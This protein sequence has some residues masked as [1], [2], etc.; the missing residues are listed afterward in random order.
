MHRIAPHAVGVVHEPIEDAVGWLARIDVL[1][2]DDWAMAPLSEP[3][4]LKLASRVLVKHRRVTG[5][6]SRVQS[7][8]Q[9]NFDLPK[10][11][12]QTA[13][14]GQVFSL[15]LDKAMLQTLVGE[16]NKLGM[17]TSKLQIEDSQGRQVSVSSQGGR[18]ILDTS[19]ATASPVPTT[20]FNSPPATSAPST[21]T[22]GSASDA[23]FV[24]QLQK[25]VQVMS[26]FGGAWNLNPAYFATRDTAQWLANKFGTGEVVEVPYGGQGGPFAATATE[27]QIKLHNGKMVNAGLLADYYQRAPEAKFPGIADE[28]IRADLI[29]DNGPGAV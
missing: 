1:A 10:P 17:D 22:S 15:S 19:A 23:P 2:I 5:M 12:T 9:T 14:S 18:Q 3:E 20:P 8:P 11:A 4:S 24:P 26:S 27:Y 6:L 28:M 21:A 29:K 7:Q 13:D 25:D 16:L